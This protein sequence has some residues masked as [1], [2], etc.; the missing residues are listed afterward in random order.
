MVWVTSPQKGVALPVKTQASLA[1]EATTLGAIEAIEDG[2]AERTIKSFSGTN[3]VD[4]LN[5][6]S[7]LRSYE[8]TRNISTVTKNGRG[9][10]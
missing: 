6:D 4:S 5:G 1:R 8:E 7:G 9:A 2:C 10:T 3:H